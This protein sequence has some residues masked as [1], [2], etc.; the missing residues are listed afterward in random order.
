V[1]SYH[2]TV[3][4]LINACFLGIG[5]FSEM[6][7]LKRPYFIQSY[8]QE[9]RLKES[10]LR[11]SRV[12]QVRCVMVKSKHHRRR[13]LKTT[14]NLYASDYSKTIYSI[15]QFLHTFC[16][17]KLQL[18]SF[19]HIVFVCSKPNINDIFISYFIVYLNIQCRTLLFMNITVVI[20]DICSVGARFI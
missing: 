2:S 10:G 6:I 17:N 3:K 9:Q 20:G 13:S 4:V 1:K 12:F 19:L 5:V 15:D 16:R 7:H 8:K 11:R 18:I 14:L